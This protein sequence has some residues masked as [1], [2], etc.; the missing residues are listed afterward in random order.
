MLLDKPTHEITEVK[1]EDVMVLQDLYNRAGVS[2][3]GAI[4]CLDQVATG[5]AKHFV[6]LNEDKLIASCLLGTGCSNGGKICSLCVDTDYNGL[7][8]GKSLVNYAIKKGGYRLDSYKHRVSFYT[9]QGF[10]VINV[11]RTVGGDKGYSMIL[12]DR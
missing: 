4:Y 8:L 12:K 7:G 1:I 10:K 5:I 2:G 11:F 6:I 9:M 3:W